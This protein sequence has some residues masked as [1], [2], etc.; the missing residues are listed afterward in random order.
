MHKFQ[1]SEVIGPVPGPM[2]RG[3]LSAH[4]H[5]YNC[6]LVYSFVN[7]VLSNQ[8]LSWT[9]DNSL[10]FKV[11]ILTHRDRSWILWKFLVS[12]FSNSMLEFL[13]DVVRCSLLDN[14]LD[15]RRKSWNLSHAFSSDYRHLSKTFNKSYYLISKWQSKM[16]SF[17]HFFKSIHGKRFCW[18]F[19][20][21]V[22]SVSS[23]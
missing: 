3:Q 2:T 18:T 15:L 4:A 8:K 21:T 11:G 10:F 22:W 14:S 6:K 17:S 1:R 5:W 9:F 19:S 7:N 13:S 20:N 23:L 16:L 12:K